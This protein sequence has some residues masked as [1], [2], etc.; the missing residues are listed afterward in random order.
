MVNKKREMN[1]NSLKNLK[2]FTSENQPKPER[3]SK[4]QIERWQ[5]KNMCDMMFQRLYKKGGCDLA[6]DGA[7]EQAK[8]GDLK[9]LL[10]LIKILKPNEA[11]QTQIINAMQNVQKI[12]VSEED[13]KQ[14]NKHI[15][16]I[17]NG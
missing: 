6:V 15:E 11:Q 5:R 3:K 10:E 16:S 9:A 7:I 2:P 8:E 12:Y 1:E 4:G 17:I 13:K 14:V